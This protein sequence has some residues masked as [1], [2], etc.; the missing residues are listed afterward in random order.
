MSRCVG[1]GDAG[2]SINAPQGPAS[3]PSD[4][5]THTHAPCIWGCL[6]L[7]AGADWTGPHS[8]QVLR[9][10]RCAQARVWPA[11][12]LIC[13]ADQPGEQRK[14]TGQRARAPES[15]LNN[16]WGEPG[17]GLGAG[18]EAVSMYLR[19]GGHKPGTPFSPRQPCISIQF[20]F[21]E[22]LFSSLYLTGLCVER[23]TLG[24]LLNSFTQSPTPLDSRKQ[25]CLFR[26]A[27]SSFPVLPQIEWFWKP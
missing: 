11:S 20:P 13:S 25:I 1:D 23:A 7:I 16:S 12:H 5:H 24:I 8:P 19:L 21:P 6:W 26:W 10:Q 18:F 17:W 27:C 3:K 15:F 22:F 14:A 2:F 9:Q 4:K